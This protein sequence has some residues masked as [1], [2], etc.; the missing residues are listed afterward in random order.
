[1]VGR[2]GCRRALG[3]AVA[4]VGAAALVLSGPVGATASRS[5]VGSGKY[6][7]AAT[8]RCLARQHNV[9]RVRPTGNLVIESAPG[10]AVQALMRTKNDVTLGFYRG[11]SD[12]RSALDF[13]TRIRQHRGQSTPGSQFHTLANVYLG[14][15]HRPTATELKAVERC[16]R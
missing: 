15:H 13:M 7:L 8:K 9:A 12:A 2:T 5:T 3:A 16:L 6:S 14:W 4:A 11:A 10:G 1:M